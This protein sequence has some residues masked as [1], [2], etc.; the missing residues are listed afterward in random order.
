MRDGICNSW[1]VRWIESVVSVNMHP[2]VDICW[3]YSVVSHSLLR[4]WPHQCSTHSQDL[5]SRT[6]GSR[7]SM[8]YYIPCAACQW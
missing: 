5:G 6:P 1:T 3:I 2:E 7:D 8:I 4:T